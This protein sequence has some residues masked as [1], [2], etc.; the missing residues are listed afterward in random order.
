MIVFIFIIFSHHE[1]NQVETLVKSH[2]MHTNQLRSHSYSPLMHIIM[3]FFPVKIQSRIISSHRCTLKFNWQK[4]ET[5]IRNERKNEYK[6]KTNSTCKYKWNAMIMMLI[7][8]LSACRFRSMHRW[9][10][11]WIVNVSGDYLWM[12]DLKEFSIF[13]CVCFGSCSDSS[14][15]GIHINRNHYTYIN[16]F[17]LIQYVDSLFFHVCA[18]Y[19]L[20][21]M[22]FFLKIFIRK[23]ELTLTTRISFS[24]SVY[25]FN[26]FIFQFGFKI[27]LR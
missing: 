10:I 9:F 6:K 24:F 8:Q 3:L 2:F 21:H 16:R 23:N 12:F 19:I 18:R 11:D 20:L 27:Q 26:L 13:L 22:C 15:L 4:D 14:R 5:C 1:N 25:P 7:W 17:R